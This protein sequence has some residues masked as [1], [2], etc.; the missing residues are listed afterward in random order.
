MFDVIVVGIGAAGLFSLSVLDR[1]LNVLAI[2]K[3]EVAGRK[4]KI[5]GG[6]RCNLTKDYDIKTFPN[7][8]T[9]PSFVRPV[10][11]GY[12]NKKLMDYFVSGGLALTI[13]DSKVFPKTEKAQSVIDFFLG[14]IEH[15]GHKMNFS[16][17]VVD[18]EDY[19]DKIVVVTDKGR[20]TTRNLIIASGGKAYK[21]VGSNT[22]IIEKLFDTSA[23]ESGLSPI[24]IDS[25]A[26]RDL[27][28]VSMK[29]K[30]SF[31]GKTIEGPML[32][33]G[34]YL[35]GPAIFDASNYLTSGEVFTV[36]FLPEF[37]ESLLRATIVEKLKEQP[38]KLVKS[39]IQMSFDLS[40]SF[41]NAVFSDLKMVDIKAA[42]LKKSDLTKLVQYLKA[43]ELTVS[44]KFALDKAY[45]TVGGVNVDCID[46]K[47]MAL[48]ENDRIYIVGEALEPL[49]QSGGFNLQFAFSSAMCSVNNI[50]FKYN[51]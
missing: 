32:F 37:N 36:D 39:I 21:P 38:K 23:F 3:N 47:T 43:R 20:H 26:F 27:S 30:L 11:H 13:E 41:V 46:N 22:E 17:T 42:D 40:E 4:L 15:N 2:E 1:S 7:F 33:A 8:Y 14:K 45:G 51:I 44:S 12:S 34:R 50:H 24:Y 35:S 49:G 16:E 28:G 48:K 31:A 9:H 6:G 29:V 18:I 10:L 25:Q 5:T 19:G